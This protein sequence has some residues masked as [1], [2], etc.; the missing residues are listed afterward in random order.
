MYVGTIYRCHL[1]VRGERSG[2]AVTC[3]RIEKCRFTKQVPVRFSVV[4]LLRVG[5]CSA[6]DILPIYREKGKTS[7]LLLALCTQLHFLC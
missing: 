4:P 2:E 5:E 1:R 3:E 7:M 6:P